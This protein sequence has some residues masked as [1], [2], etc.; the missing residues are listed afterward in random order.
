MSHVEVW[1]F[2][3]VHSMFRGKQSP[4]Y[5]WFCASVTLICSC[6][7]LDICASVTL[8]WHYWMVLLSFRI[9]S[10]FKFFNNFFKWMYSLVK[11][12]INGPYLSFFVGGEG[13]SIWG[14]WYIILVEMCAT[15]VYLPMIYLSR[16]LCVNKYMPVWSIIKLA[17][18][19]S[20]RVS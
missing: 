17:W 3:C 14:R 5:V 4:I 10:Q 2:P 15:F 11:L 18:S 8:I 19:D 20:S 9:S 7:R 13:C 1:Y 16:C 12:P 6:S